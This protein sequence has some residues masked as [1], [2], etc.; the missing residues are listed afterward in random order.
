M[1]YY[2]QLAGTR[3]AG[4]SEE[5]YYKFLTYA[6]R[7]YQRS[8]GVAALTQAGMSCIFTVAGY[9]TKDNNA[10]STSGTES[11]DAERKRLQSELDAVLK[12]IGAKDQNDINEAISRA[13]NTRDENIAAQQKKGDEQV[14]S[15]VNS[16]DSKIKS[17]QNELAS[18]TDQA[19]IDKIN[20]EITK[21][22]QE[23]E[24]KVK[25]AQ[26]K[27]NAELKKVTE[28]ENNKLTM[29]CNNATDAFALLE[30]LAN[31]NAVD[32][33]SYTVQEKTEVLN[34]FVTHRNILNSKNDTLE[35]KQYAAKRIKELA[36]EN[37]DNKT[38]Q[39]GYK[40]IENQVN[41][42][43]N[44]NDTYRT[45]DTTSIGNEYYKDKKPAV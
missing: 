28:A 4:M 16:Y 29:I 13:Q 7:N 34:E 27:A 33:D 30:A 44:G 43:L 5:N 39:D 37:P 10:D 23:A 14:Q 3:D 26:E 24:T 19:T 8:E 22:Q 32:E 12:A 25:E 17:K 36:E 18:A 9:F 40:M 38:L 45:M 35:T 2:T 31:L 6:N 41:E 11:E 15:V 21:L 42:I 1:G 20:N